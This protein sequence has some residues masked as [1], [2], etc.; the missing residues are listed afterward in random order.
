MVGV[1]FFRN[2]MKSVNLRQIAV[3]LALGMCGILPAHADQGHME[4][5]LNALIQA[6]YELTQASPNKGGHRE[7]AIQIINEAIRQVKLGISVGASH[8]D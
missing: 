3:F 7:K 2:P 1:G 5:A 4:R 6:R 8:G